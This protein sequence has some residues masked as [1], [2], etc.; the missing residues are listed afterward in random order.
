MR[1]I[2]YIRVSTEEQKCSG[3]G[4]DAQRSTIEG[5]AE[6]QGWELLEIIADEG[7]SGKS[8][9]RRPGLRRAFEIVEAGEA[10][11]IVVAKLDRL[12]RSL[13]DFAVTFEQAKAQGWKLIPLDLGIDPSTASGEMMANV[14]ASFAHYERRLI[15]DRTKAALAEKRAQGATLG[16]PVVLA[17]DVAARIV[18][19]REAGKSYQAIA[20]GL[21]A[22]GIPTAHGG[23]LWRPS[24]VRAVVKRAERASAA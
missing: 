9:S 19:D 22:D 11:A 21:N 12:S 7:I 24:S 20:A 5:E 16:R 2:G 4:L 18:S 14:M 1:V 3:L 13:I 17:D 6:R 23:K 15:S 8:I 10:E